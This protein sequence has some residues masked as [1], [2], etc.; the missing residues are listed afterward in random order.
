MPGTH[1]CNCC[2]GVWV[3]QTYVYMQ[4]KTEFSLEGYT[5]F[6]VEIDH[7]VLS[8]LLNEEKDLFYT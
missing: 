1:R 5:R 3:Y 8:I 6:N 2:D 4:L 7:H